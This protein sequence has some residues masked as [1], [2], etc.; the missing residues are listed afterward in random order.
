MSQ[1]LQVKVD[2]QTINIDESRLSAIEMV[3]LGNNQYHIIYPG[4][5]MMVEIEQTGN[6]NRLSIKSGNESYNVTLLDALQQQIEKMGMNAKMDLA[7]TMLKAPMP[8]LVLD[9]CVNEGDEVQKGDK[10]IVLEAMKME[11]A[12]LAPAN[13]TIKKIAVKK[14]DSVEKGALLIEFA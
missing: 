3:S 6:G 2:E 13:V 9:I 8:G 1:Q 12:L 10:L 14:G 4:G 11:N 7:F 5:K